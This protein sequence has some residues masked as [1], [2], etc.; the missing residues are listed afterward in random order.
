M[1]RDRYNLIAQRIG[2]NQLFARPVLPTDPLRREY[3]KL[4]QIQS[5]RGRCENRAM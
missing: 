2:R 1:F 5:L 4:T 3:H